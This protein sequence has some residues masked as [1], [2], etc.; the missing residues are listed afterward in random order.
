MRRP[1]ASIAPFALLASEAK[2]VTQWT[3]VHLHHAASDIGARIV[4]LQ[5]QPILPGEQAF[6][7]L[8]LDQPIAAASGDRFVL[9]DTTAQRTIGGGQFV[10]LRAPARKRRTPERMAQIEAQAIAD[11]EASLSAL[12]DRPPFFVDLSDLR[13]R[14]RA[15][16]IRDG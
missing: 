12:L 2:P 9:R 14:P 13:P 6:A 3:P 5:D 8:V 15:R 4:L 7:Q 1:T 11:P 10:D 16:P